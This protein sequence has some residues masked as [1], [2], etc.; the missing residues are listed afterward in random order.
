MKN[1]KKILFLLFITSLVCSFFNLLSGFNVAF[2]SEPV[3]KTDTVP[4]RNYTV[5]I[6]PGHGGTDPGSIGYKTKIHEADL[7]LKLSIMLKEKLESAGI[8]VVMTRQDEKAMVEG[9]GK[10][11]KR[12]DMEAR[13]E[14]IKKARPNM[15]I[16]LHQNS[17]TNHTLRGAQVFYD[18]TSDISKQIAEF[19][20]CEFKQNLDNSIKATSPGDYFIL[21]C[22]LAPSVI[23]EC[24]FLSNAE[25]E[26]LLLSPD[27][28]EKI[29]D[30]IY[31]GIIKFLQIK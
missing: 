20:Q 7:N 1:F 16:S 23:V 6:D 4:S 11:W 14:L 3:S 2:A 31:K 13:K 29:V 15:V 24:G 22:S 19:I 30:C 21:K 25:E 12:A 27:Y 28:Q 17:Y 9:A 18:K 26:K 8:N 10:K 5:L